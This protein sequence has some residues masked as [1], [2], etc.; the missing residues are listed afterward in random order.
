MRWDRVILMSDFRWGCIAVVLVA[1]YL[2]LLRRLRDLR[3][4][5]YWTGLSG[6]IVFIGSHILVRYARD[7]EIAVCVAVGI[8]GG[9]IAL[10]CAALVWGKDS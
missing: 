4:W 10:V 7:A 8:L 5:A 2:Y 3:R 6:T 1:Y 9:I